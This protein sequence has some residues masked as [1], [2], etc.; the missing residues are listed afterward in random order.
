ME[1]LN[2]L[3][4]GL[5]G[6]ANGAGDGGWLSKVMPLVMLGGAGAGTVGNI[7]G[8]RSKNSVLSAEMAQMAKLSGLTPDQVSKAIQGMTQPISA[9]LTKAV[10]NQVQGSLA[11]RGLAQAPGIF[12]EQM[13]Q[14]LAPYQIQAQQLATDQYFKTLGMPISARP[15][16]FGPFP[17]QTNTSGIW[18]T[19]AQR[20]LNPS[21]KSPTGGDSVAPGTSYGPAMDPAFDLG[22]SLPT[23]L[24]PD[25]MSSWMA[26]MQPQAAVP[27]GMF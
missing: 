23:N 25:F 24:P 9:G 16:P 21:G 27:Q 4:S 6:A 2:N 14:N 22:G 20:Y 13:T 5:G 1:G 17:S 15:S 7:L 11:E 19:L 3:I 10:G 8:D 26:S 18:Q 12:G